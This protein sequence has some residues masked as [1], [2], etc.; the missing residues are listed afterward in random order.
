MKRLLFILFLSVLAHG[1]MMQTIVSA[2]PL[3]QDTGITFSPPA[4]AVS[5]PTTVTFSGAIAGSIYCSTQDGST[6]KT[7]GIGTACVTGSLGNTTSITSAVTV[8]VVSGLLGELDSA[9]SSAA[10]TITGGAPTHTWVQSNV[11]TTCLTF[12]GT[13]QGCA[14]G[15]NVTNGNLVVVVAMTNDGTATISDTASYSF[16]KVWTA[17]GDTNGCYHDANGEYICSWYAIANSTH[18]ETITISAAS[19]KIQLG[20]QEF[21]STSTWTG[22]DVEK[23]GTPYAF[24]SSCS[25]GASSAVA[26]AGELIIGFA[27]D[28]DDDTWGATGA[29]TTVDSNATTTNRAAMFYTLAGASGTQTASFTNSLGFTISGVMAFKP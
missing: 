7:N 1:Q 24:A 14:F 8:K 17:E 19:G 10:Y 12:S 11:P 3:S 29:P 16:S 9:V 5:N 21:H 2:K 4:G 25:S 6:P 26:A 23:L 20:I 13:S 28:N 15:S 18:S 22:L 27:N